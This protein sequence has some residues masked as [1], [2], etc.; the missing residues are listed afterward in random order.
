MRSM[1]PTDFRS[2]LQTIK[3]CQPDE[4]YHLAGQTSVGLS[5]EQPAEAL[6]LYRS[7][8]PRAY[9]AIAAV[10]EGNGSTTTSRSSLS[11]PRFWSSPR[12]CELGA[13]PQ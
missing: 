1:A 4:I 10:A 6:E 9:A 3:R 12:V 13:W 11:M 5:F 8:L 7:A 2:V